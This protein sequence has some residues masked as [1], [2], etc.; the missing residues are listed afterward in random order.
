M[1]WTTR[2][3][4]S[5]SGWYSGLSFATEAARSLTVQRWTYSRVIESGSVGSGVRSTI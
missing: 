5:A 4:E 1:Y 3:S 2:L